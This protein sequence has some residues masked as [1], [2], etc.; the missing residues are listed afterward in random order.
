MSP[1][2]S[3]KIYFDYA[4]VL[5]LLVL[6]SLGIILI[7]Y[8]KHKKFKTPNER[9]RAAWYIDYA[10]SFFPVL[11]LVWLIR[12]FIIQPYRVPTG[13]LEPT[14]LPGEFIVTKQY[15]YGLRL[16]VIECKIF[17][18]G[19][20]KLG[21][22]AL[23]R[24]PNNPSVIFVKRVIGLP[25]DHIVYKNKTLFI[26]GKIALQKPIGWA[27]DLER[28]GEKVFEKTEYL[29]NG[30]EHKIFLRLNENFDENIDVKVPPDCYFMMGDNRDGSN[31]S[32]YWGFVPA[33]NL[34]G[35]AFAIWLSIDWQKCKI[36]WSRIFNEI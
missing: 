7:D 4:F 3:M 9:K 1:D 10:Y 35:Q 23:F 18:I 22:I 33:K 12:S 34:I 17:D 14:I 16:P 13:S 2:E 5:T 20:P 24:W 27:E 36:R 32:R 25:N 19:A 6:L 28:N 30:V 11:L 31:D 21:D 8:L 29:P 15:S 26:N